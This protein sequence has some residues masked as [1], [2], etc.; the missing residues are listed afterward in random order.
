MAD[1]FKFG[2]FIKNTNKRRE[3]GAGLPTP[4]TNPPTQSEKPARTMT[5]AEFSYGV[6]GTRRNPKK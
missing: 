6:E 1:V 4:S 3:K 2:G 5:Q